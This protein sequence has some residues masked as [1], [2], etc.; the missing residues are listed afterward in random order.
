MKRKKIHSNSEEGLFAYGKTS[1]KM[2]H[3]EMFTVRDQD[4]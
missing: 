3:Q 1:K 2:S 4:N